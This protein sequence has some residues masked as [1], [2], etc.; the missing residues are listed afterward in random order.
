MWKDTETNIIDEY[1]MVKNTNWQEADQL[2]I[3]KRS[4]GVELGTTANNTS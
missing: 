2:A 3:W 1:N 4:R